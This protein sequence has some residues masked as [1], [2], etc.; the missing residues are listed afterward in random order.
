MLLRASDLANACG[1]RTEASAAVK[2]PEFLYYLRECWSQKG[3]LLP[4]INVSYFAFW[5]VLH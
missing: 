5:S 3:S 2:G 4:V 1:R